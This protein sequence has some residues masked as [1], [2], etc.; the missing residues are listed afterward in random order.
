[1]SYFYKRMTY[2]KSKVL[3]LK[4]PKIKNYKYTELAYS[5]NIH[6]ISSEDEENNKPEFL[7]NTQ[8][9]NANLKKKINII[10][11]LCSNRKGEIFL[12]DQYGKTKLILKNATLEQ[13]VIFN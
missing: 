8:Q 3:A 6:N 12:E 5:S 10:G 1:M 2:L 4:N 7:A 11:M 13:N 9:M